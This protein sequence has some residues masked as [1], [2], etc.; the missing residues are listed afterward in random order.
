MIK[1]LLSFDQAANLTGW[2]YWEDEKPKEWGVITPLP[3]SAKGGQRL[4]SLY[5]QYSALVA[6]YKPEIIVCEPPIGDDDDGKGHKTLFVLSQVMGL[7]QMI[8]AKT[9]TTLELM[10]AAR[11]QFNCGIHKRDRAERKAGA[12]AFIEKTYHIPQ[13]EISQDEVDSLCIAHSYFIQRDRDNL[14][15]E[16]AF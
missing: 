2:S 14:T 1:R 4:N 5:G 16:C 15:E 9:L 7:I 10:P 11:W 3:K 8:S 12:K 13:E 6:K